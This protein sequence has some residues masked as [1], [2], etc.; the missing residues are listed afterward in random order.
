MKSI[1]EIK[2][3]SPLVLIIFT[4]KAAELVA[5]AAEKNPK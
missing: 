5:E 2:Y 1:F 3:Q 4:V